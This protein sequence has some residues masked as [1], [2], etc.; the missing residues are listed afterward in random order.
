MNQTPFRRGGFALI[1]ISILL[2]VAS[3]VLVTILPSSQT[4]L[5]ANNATTTKMNTILTALRKF[6]A[7]NG[8]L[9]CPADASQ[10]IGSTTYGVVAANSGATNNCSGGSPAANF[11]DAA[12]HT[13]IGMVPARA[14]GLS[15]D[16][17]LDGY[18]R[19][20]TY[21][22]DTAATSCWASTSLPG[23]IVVAENWITNNTVAALVSHGADG[24]GAWMPRPGASGTAV[25]LN[26]GS[27]DVD[28]LLNAHLTTG[29]FPT[30]TGS[31]QV[32]DSGGSTVTFVKK[33]PNA[34]FD[35]LVV[36]R[37]P[38]WNINSLPVVS[39]TTVA[40]PANGS[41]STGQTLTFTLT[42]SSAVT[43]NTSGGTP[44]LSLSAISG[45]M[46]T[47]NVAKAYYQSGS[48]TTVLT[49]SYTIISSDSAATGLTMAPAI[50]LNG[51]TIQNGGLCLPVPNLS[52]VLVNASPWVYA[53]AVTIDHTKV[54]TVNNTDQTNFPVLFSGTYSYLT[55]QANGGNVQ[56][57]S[58]YDIIFTS[59]SACQ[60][61]LSFEQ[62]SYNPST[63]AVVYW[64][65]V[66]T[67]SHSAST[68]IYLCY[69]NS[70]ITTFQ[71]TPS[72]TWDGNFQGVWHMGES[73]GTTLH[74]S[75]SNANNA[76]KKGAS[77]PAPTSSGEIGGGQTFVGTL[78]STN[79]DYA[80]FSS[81]TPATNTWTIEWWAYETNAIYLDSV[82]LQS[83]SGNILFA[84]YYW[85]PNGSLHWYNNY[86]TS[87]TPTPPSAAS[88]NNWHHVV[89]VR[90]GDSMNVYLDGVAGTAVTG[91]GTSTAQFKGLGWDGV[92]GY[93]CSFNGTLD[94]ARLSNTVRSA[95]WIVTEYNNQSSPSTFY[96]VGAAV[97]P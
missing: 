45:N 89:F 77:N 85:Y 93:D 41:Y 57:A 29:T 87:L 20:I 47:S 79:N 30:S 31:S 67:V 48:G 4:N 44:Y 25:R 56:N 62:E 59:D 40:P 82:F 46:G 92:A 9:P 84:G 55:T 71:S 3:L 49:F 14:L 53:R 13:A 60:N 6:Q 7:A 27:T 68:V 10:P 94:E 39:Q 18:G 28:Q 32:T 24:H 63:G 36:Y 66:P 73:S 72:S 1:Q 17:T 34:T 2:V 26:A 21:A 69:D 50:T 58:G 33:A 65:K 43:V 37:S 64:V 70:T 54:G 23:N 90:N 42:F 97:T 75:T 96:T 88:L 12:N 19:D 11:V 76:I 86:N 8:W 61:S 15:N 22:V 83:D 78:N 74:D 91:N 51:G 81:L 38:L 16:Y 52:G 35:D 5:T 80:L 95:D